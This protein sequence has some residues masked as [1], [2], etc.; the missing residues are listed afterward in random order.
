MRDYRRLSRVDWKERDRELLP[1]LEQF[2]EA[3]RNAHPELDEAAIGA[4]EWKF[5][6]DWR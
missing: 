4:L 5:S 2:A 6:W 3:F 1:A